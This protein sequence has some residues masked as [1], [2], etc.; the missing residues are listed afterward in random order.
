[1]VRFNT[2]A[3]TTTIVQHRKKMNLLEK[4]RE[5]NI[6][7]SP[8][9]WYVWKFACWMSDR[10]THFKNVSR[11]LLCSITKP[12]NKFI[13]LEF[14]SIQIWMWKSCIDQGWPDFFAQ[15]PNLNSNNYC[16]PQFFNLLMIFGPY[17]PF[18][19]IFL[20]VIERKIRHF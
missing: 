17:F 18:L 15:E 13:L 6:C 12:R 16:G 1:M 2:T 10:Q 14:D 8:P 5:R 11:K 20:M 19:F 3:K 7:S 4:S 9:S